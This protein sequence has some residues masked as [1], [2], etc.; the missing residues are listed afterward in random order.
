MVLVVCMN[1]LEYSHWSQN[2][3]APISDNGI[4]SFVIRS[5]SYLGLNLHPIKLPPVRIE[6][7][8][9]SITGLKFWCSAN[10]ANQTC[11]T[12]E[13]FNWSLFHAPFPILDF[14]HFRIIRTWFFKDSDRQ[15]NVNLVQSETYQSISQDFLGYLRTE[16][17]FSLADFIL[18]QFVW[19]KFRL[20]M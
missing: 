14:D 1:R 9:L 15:P 16:G 10:C 11:A 5:T 8:K 3:S 19:C 2:L 17:S 6:P 20:K 4:E 7:T 18:L 13:I 12:W